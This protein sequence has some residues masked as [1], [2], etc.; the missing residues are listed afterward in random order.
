M[1]ERPATIGCVD[2][3]VELFSSPPGGT[4]RAAVSRGVTLFG[5]CSSILFVGFVVCP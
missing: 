2:A 5:P 4:M 1:D 3:A